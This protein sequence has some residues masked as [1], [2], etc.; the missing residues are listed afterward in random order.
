MENQNAIVKNI[1]DKN[2]DDYKTKLDMKR[3]HE[4]DVAEADE[5]ILELRKELRKW[6]LKRRKLDVERRGYQ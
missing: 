5:K 6:E 4:E 1:S 2:E 3:L